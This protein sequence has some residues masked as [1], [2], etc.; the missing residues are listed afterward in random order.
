M[1]IVVLKKLFL[2]IKNVF[3]DADR[4]QIEIFIVV[5]SFAFHYIKPSPQFVINSPMSNECSI[6]Y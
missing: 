6:K 1:N 3:C 2:I 5:V 4:D